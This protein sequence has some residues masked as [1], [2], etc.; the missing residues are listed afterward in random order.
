MSFRSAMQLI[1]TIPLVL[2]MAACQPASQPPETGEI[3]GGVYCDQNANGD[4]DC[5]EQGF[6]DIR[7]HLYADACGGQILQSVMTSADGSFQFADLQPGQY[8]VF[9]D[10]QPMCG[11]VAGYDLTTGISRAVLVK[12]NHTHELLWFGLTPVMRSNQGD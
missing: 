6:S 8:C 2:A 5:A 1:W 3:I 11:G 9:V 10:I 4:C 12:A 7:I